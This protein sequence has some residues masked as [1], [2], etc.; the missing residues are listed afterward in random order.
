MLA[1]VTI[2]DPSATAIDVDVT[3]GEDTTI[4]PFSFLR[5]APRSAP[6]RLSAH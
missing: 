4:E 2:A 6:V 1:G 3:I 5:G